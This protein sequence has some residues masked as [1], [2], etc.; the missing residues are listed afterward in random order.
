MSTESV[1]RSSG[2]YTTIL[3]ALNQFQAF[4]DLQYSPMPTTTLNAKYASD[5]A[6]R[7]VVNLQ[8]PPT[9]PALAYFGIG[10]RGFMNVGSYS[11]VAYPGDARMMDLYAPIPIRCIRTS[12]EVNMSAEERDKYRLR[13]VKTLDDGLE[14]ALYYLK[15]IEFSPTIEV[16]SKDTDGRENTFTFDPSTWLY[17]PVV[18]SLDETGGFIN[19]NINRVIVRA[20]GICTV[21]H[22]E[23][24][25]AVNHMHNGD[26]NY[27]R[28]SE[29]GYYTGC[30]VG[31][32]ADWTY[33]ESSSDIVYNEAAYVQ[34]AKGH[35]FRGS[36]L[37]TPGSVIKP[38]VTFESESC[39]NVSVS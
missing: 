1:L 17:N 14:Y 4:T 11:S 13:V 7:G 21:T 25:E 23:I 36:E 10:T 34:L 33:T 26:T 39:I 38:V 37:T 15:K 20:K 12:D 22:D 19:T 28:V 31:V 6:N 24:M 29:I 9:T 35:C 30:E 18:P 2:V 16:V 32:N 5:P 3:G 27:A 8:Q